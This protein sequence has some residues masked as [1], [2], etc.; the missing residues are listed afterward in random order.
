M[1]NIQVGQASLPVCP[2][3]A[4]ADFC[5]S[6]FIRP[7]Q[8]SARRYNEAKFEGY[9]NF[10]ETRT[11]R[12][13]GVIAVI[14]ALGLLMG[15]GLSAEEEK[16]TVKRLP[17]NPIITPQTDPSI[18]TNINGPSLIRV[19]NWVQKP[20][21]RYYLYF[22]DHKG[23]Y[24]RL[25]Y[26]DKPQ[27]PYKV[28]QPGTLQLAQS[29]FTD[30]IASPEAL[31]DEE[32]HQI[33]LYYHGLTPEEKVQHTRVAVSTDGLHFTATKAPVGNGSAYWR[34]FHYKG[35]WYALAM[36][37]KLY[38]SKDGLTPF[39]PGPALFPA[40][41]TQVHNA[42]LLRGDT[43]HV[44]YTRSGDTPERILTSRVPLGDDWQQWKPTPPQ[45][46]L[47]P[48]TKWEGSDLPLTAGRIGAADTPIRAL[49]DP[50]IFQEDG[51]TYLLYAVAG[52]SG[53]AIAEIQIPSGSPH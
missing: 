26:A 35:W 1:P 51:K 46:C 44:F 28:Y 14:G 24:I 32:H 7:R 9:E 3:A 43:L 4:Q 36:P 47:A 40:T 30:H 38:R 23:K 42:V 41:P 25:A 31:V 6:E 50:A 11:M 20:L 53:I 52:E 15:R 17:E 22:A 21:G 2:K 39:E 45:E 13:I 34:L 5:G 18:G 16:L 29:Y 19:P 27:G 10:R 37:G 48:E 33:R 8:M 49:R 12:R